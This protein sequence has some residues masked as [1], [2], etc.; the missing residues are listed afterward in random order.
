MSKSSVSDS[1][2]SAIFD[3]WPE[4]AI[5]QNPP[6]QAFCFEPLF[7]QDLT[8]CL[9]TW[10]IGYSNSTIHLKIETET[11]TKLTTMSGSIADVY[12]LY[13]EKRQSGFITVPELPVNSITPMKSYD[14]TESSIREWPVY[15][16]VKIDGIRMLCRGS[17]YRSSS[18]RV[19]D[20]S[21]SF[22]DDLKRLQHFLPSDAT[23]DGELYAHHL[24]IRT[25]RSIIQSKTHSQLSE[26]KYYIFDVAL[27]NVKQFNMPYNQR[28]ELLVQAFTKCCQYYGRMPTGLIIVP[29]Q[30]A[31]SHIEILNHHQ[32]YVSAGYEGLMVRKF[33][34]YKSDRSNHILKYKAFSDKEYIIV[35]IEKTG[36]V[37]KTESGVLFAV[38]FRDKD[39]SS[40]PTMVGKY[41]TVRFISVNSD[42]TPINPV[43]IAIRDYE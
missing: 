35:S 36:A 12:R 22:I 10:I 42:Q 23:I 6:V 43:A 25:L 40:S 9:T 19:Y 3:S 4:I 17:S 29:C 37:V 39:W 7:R 41:L 5:H 20:K 18:N 31:T 13:I 38:P 1:A 27:A 30:L 33:L 26:V 32:L 2:D 24:S 8:G 16:Q 11:E 21:F 34:P 28:F 15:T 14:Y